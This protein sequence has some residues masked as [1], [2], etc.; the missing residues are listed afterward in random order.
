V[1]SPA[2]AIDTAGNSSFGE[3]AF[4]VYNGI[5]SSVNFIRVQGAATGAFPYLGPSVNSGDAN[6]DMAV[7]AKGTGNVRFFSDTGGVEMARFVRVATAD[8]YLTFTPSNGGNPA[9]DVSGG[10]LKLGGAADIQWG[11]ALVAL[12]GGAVP[13]LGTIGGTG[14]AAAA[15]NTW[16]RVLD[17]TGA[18]F[19]VPAWK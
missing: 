9:I 15:Q 8:R 2:L 18:A 13:T 1:A 16:M 3:N 19:W 14:P 17:S 4:E 12:G 5:A 10:N 6:V 11:V 7:Y